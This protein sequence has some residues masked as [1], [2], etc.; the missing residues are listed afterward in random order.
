M[1]TLILP[2]GM[3]TG[4]NVYELLGSMPEHKFGL[5]KIAITQAFHESPSDTV[6]WSK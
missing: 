3:Y 2:V 5:C 4:E 6:D 1:K